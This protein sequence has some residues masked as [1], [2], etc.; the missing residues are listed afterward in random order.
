MG[1]NNCK[2]ADDMQDLIEDVFNYTYSLLGIDILYS[3]LWWIG[4]VNVAL[5]IAYFMV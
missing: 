3:F 5:Q 1:A 2:S 4:P